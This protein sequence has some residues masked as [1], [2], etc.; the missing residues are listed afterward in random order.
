MIKIADLNK[1]SSPQDLTE[2]EAKNIVGGLDRTT[3]SAIDA[4]NQA[5]SNMAEISAAS[6]TTNVSI[7]TSTATMNISK[8]FSEGL[9]SRGR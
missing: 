3:Q 4:M 9:S 1:K 6:T 2:S 7:G 5:A 8:L